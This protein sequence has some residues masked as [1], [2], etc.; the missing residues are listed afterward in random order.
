MWKKKILLLPFSISIYSLLTLNQTIKDFG[1]LK[2][3][4]LKAEKEKEF[5]LHTLKLDSDHCRVTVMGEPKYRVSSSHYL[6]L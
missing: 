3:F 6:P 1:L 5:L 2:V 4:S